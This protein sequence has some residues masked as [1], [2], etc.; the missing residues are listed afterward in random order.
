MVACLYG[1]MFVWLHVCMVACLYGCMFVWLHVCMV[2]CLYGC[3]SQIRVTQF[4]GNAIF[5]LSVTSGWSLEVT[6]YAELTVAVVGIVSQ[7][8]MSLFMKIIVG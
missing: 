5:Y 4:R 6:V 8:N 3:M 1:C 2:A 7:Q